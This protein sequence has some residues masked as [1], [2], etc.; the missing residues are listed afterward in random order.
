MVDSLELSN[1]LPPSFAIV[2]CFLTSKD[3]K[4]QSKKSFVCTAMW[5][6]KGT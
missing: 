5:V 3:E 1:G 4:L 6:F 2:T